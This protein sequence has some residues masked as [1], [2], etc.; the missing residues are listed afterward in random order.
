MNHNEEKGK[1]VGFLGGPGKPE[2]VC[3]DSSRQRLVPGW[4]AGAERFLG[5]GFRGFG[6]YGSGLINLERHLL[7]RK[8]S[9]GWG[10]IAWGL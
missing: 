10:W 8:K 5:Q 9:S 2:N 6:V 3:S 7:R 4:A 1:M